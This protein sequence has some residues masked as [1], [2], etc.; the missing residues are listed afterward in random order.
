[1]YLRPCVPLSTSRLQVE[2]WLALRLD[3]QEMN[4]SARDTDVCLPMFCKLIFLCKH[5]IAKL[6]GL[7][8]SQKWWF[9]RE[10]TERQ[11]NLLLICI[12]AHPSSSSHHVDK[13][14]RFLRIVSGLI[15]GS[16]YLPASAIKFVV[17][18]AI[19]HSPVS[20]YFSQGR[21]IALNATIDGGAAP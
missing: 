5:V 2:C 7:Q 9:D 6:N 20:S 13:S 15:Y 16:C 4:K 18:A 1:M 10:R 21:F 19:F 8:G 11:N 17:P 3:C 12:S 14:Y